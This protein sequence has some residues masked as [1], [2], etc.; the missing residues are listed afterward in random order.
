MMHLV[1]LLY[2]FSY[3]RPSDWLGRPV[4]Y[5]VLSGTLNTTML[6]SLNRFIWLEVNY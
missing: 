5:N 6:F 3:Y 1:V 2:L 4:L